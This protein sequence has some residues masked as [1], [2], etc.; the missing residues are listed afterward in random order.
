MNNSNITLPKTIIKTIFQECV[1]AYYGDIVDNR[2]LK[3]L[4]YFYQNFSMI[5]K[6]CKTILPQ[7]SYDI[8]SA[9]NQ[10]DIVL[11]LNLYKQGIRVNSIKLRN[12]GLPLNTKIL[13]VLMFNSKRPG[14][15]TPEDIQS[16]FSSHMASENDFLVYMLDSLSDTNFS[17]NIYP[18]MSKEEYKIVLDYLI[19]NPLDNPEKTLDLHLG[20]PTKDTPITNQYQNIVN[21]DLLPILTQYQITSLKFT[22]YR[23]KNSLLSIPVHLSILNSIVLNGDFNITI[24]NF[25]DLVTNNPQL[26][27][28]VVN[29]NIIDHSTALSILTN[30]PSINFLSLGNNR[31]S[32]PM[33]DLVRYLNS[34]TTIRELIIYASLSEGESIDSFDIYNST[35]ESLRVINSCDLFSRWKCPSAIQSMNNIENFP[36][37]HRFHSNI[38]S[39]SS[40][41]KPVIEPFTKLTTLNV[42]S[43]LEIDEYTQLLNSISKL[44]LIQSLY[45]SYQKPFL[46]FLKHPPQS[47]MKLSISANTHKLEREFFD[48]M[49]QNQTIGNLHIFQE[50]ELSEHY[51][52]F[53]ILYKK[54]NI[55]ALYYSF[56]QSNALEIKNL[57]KE[58]LI[59]FYRSKCPNSEILLFDRLFIQIKGIDI[60]EIY[61][62]SQKLK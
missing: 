59:E 48:I 50:V 46:E 15:K 32:Q 51:G 47:L 62:Q 8:C 20:N 9:E 28:L 42:L 38:T 56:L 27:R 26:T 61:I 58:K 44:K 55:R 1:N 39:L 37:L 2:R 33:K 25:K 23:D 19:P 41:S 16:Q 22:Y 3:S 5:S 53:E 4:K 18:E 6:D 11:L 24:D 12:Y 60:H 21:S 29:V 45:I 54:P 43:S 31:Q 36:V 49:I 7:L 57:F 35:L 13:L 30:H 17:L 34:N 40:F 10:E 52:F 14:C